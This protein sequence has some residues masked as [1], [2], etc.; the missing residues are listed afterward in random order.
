[1]R[2]PAARKVKGFQRDD[3]RFDVDDVHNESSLSVMTSFVGRHID[4]DGLHC[5]KKR[6]KQKKMMSK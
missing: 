5:K 1:M 3:M 4:I 6:M 2:R